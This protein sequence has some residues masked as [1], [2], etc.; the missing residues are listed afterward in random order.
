MQHWQNKQTEMFKDMEDTAVRLGG[1]GRY[2]SSG[3]LAKYMS[4]SFLNMKSGLVTIVKLVQVMI[5]V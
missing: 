2:D 1:D 5:T 3:H 4:Y